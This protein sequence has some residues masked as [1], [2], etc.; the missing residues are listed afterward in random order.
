MIKSSKIILK[1]QTVSFTYLLQTAIEVLSEMGIEIISVDFCGK[2]YQF[3]S[4]SA[5]DVLNNKISENEYKKRFLI[6]KKGG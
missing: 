6:S 4:R 3:D 5:F 2:E 1:V